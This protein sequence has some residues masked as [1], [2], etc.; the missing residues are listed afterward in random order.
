MRTRIEAAVD[1]APYLGENGELT[2]LNKDNLEMAKFSE[3][4]DHTFRL[5]D[6]DAVTFNEGYEPPINAV[7]VPRK[8][9]PKLLD[10]YADYIASRGGMV[11]RGAI[12]DSLRH[13]LQH[14][15][16]Y[17]ELHAENIWYG[18]YVA[19]TR[20]MYGD[21]DLPRAYPHVIVPDW[22]TI[23]LAVG[24]AMLA[25]RDPNKTDFAIVENLGYAPE[26]VIGKVT[27]H[28]ALGKFPYIPEPKWAVR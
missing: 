22:K 11:S 5:D 12:D 17:K 18:I 28:N 26:E 23:K 25:P 3:Q 15:K 4:P 8:K 9:F 14:G 24:A 13:E 2:L 21:E 6:Y 7:L 1:A 10:V 20:D 27:T 16:A 19:K